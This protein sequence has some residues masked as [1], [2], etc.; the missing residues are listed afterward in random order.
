MKI[1]LVS[2]EYPDTYWGF[3]HALRLISKK[4]AVP[5]LGLITVS[6]MMPESWNK[7][8]IDLNVSKLRDS[9]ILAA[10]YVFISAMHIQKDSVT[11]I[12]CQCKKLGVKVVAGGPLFTSE[13]QQYP[14]IDHFILNE[15]EITFPLFL[16]DVESGRAEKVYRTDAYADITQTPVPD[17]HLLSRKKY[18][19]MNL[20]VTRGCPFDCDFCEI[21]SLLGHKVRMKNTRQILAELDE[22]YRLS[23]RGP[24]FIVDDNFIG[25]KR[26]V[27]NDLLPAMIQWMQKHDYPFVFNTQ[28]SINL[29][30]DPELMSLLTMAGFNST[31][32]GIETPSAESLLS[33]NKV[34]NRNRD[35]LQS[36]KTIQNAGIQVSGGFIV[37]F[38][39]DSSSVFQNQVDFI[40]QSGI[41]AAMVGLLNAPRNTGLYKRLEAENRLSEEAT[42]SNTDYTMNFKPLMDEDEL[43]KGYRHI[44]QNIYSSRPYYKR[45]RQFMLNYKKSG[46][47]YQKIA[48]SYLT[49]FLR[50]MFVIGIVKSGRSEY[51]KFFL[52]TLFRRP[53]LFMDAMTFAV[54]GYHFR[55]V[56]GLKR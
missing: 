39:S 51:W 21:T 40:Q 3:R 6:A 35:M 8:L 28:T 13:Y 52:W 11:Q 18:A 27:K 42:G 41:V 9:D 32:I 56:Y 7:K 14:D 15:A 2:P 4:A 30:D 34:Q 46:K 22:L 49:G 54:Y 1:L 16:K 33:C 20:Q 37:G 26:E 55:A 47:G 45:I 31:F 17:Y 53:G 44:I 43:Q 29:A 48:F 25:N 19:F 5:P 36:V 10:D 50:S 38:D 24:V 23:W 12:V